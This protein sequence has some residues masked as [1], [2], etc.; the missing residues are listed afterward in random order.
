MAKD[1][2]STGAD[3]QANKVNISTPIPIRGTQL[4]QID[5]AASAAINSASNPHASFEDS[6][7]SFTPN[8]QKRVPRASARRASYSTI[9]TSRE[10]HYNLDYVADRDELDRLQLDPNSRFYARSRPRTLNLPRLLPYEVENPQNQAKFLSHIVS[11][12]YIAI[13]TL[14]I[15]GSLSVSARDLA[16]LRDVSGFSDIDIAL[17]T[18]LFESGGPEKGTEADHEEDNTYFQDDIDSASESPDEEDEDDEYDN[19]NDDAKDHENTVQ[20]KKSPKS[21]AVVGVRIWTQELLVWLKMKYEMPVS[22]RMNLARVY[23]AVCLSRGQHISLK[24]YVR[25]FELLTKDIQFLRSQQFSLPWEDMYNELAHH[26]PSVDSSQ[27]RF[28]KKDHKQLLRLAERASNFFDPSSLPIIFQKLGSHFSMPN[29]SL[30]LSATALLPLNF[31]DNVDDDRDI[32]HYLSL[33]FYIWIKMNKSPGVDTHMTTRL[34]AIAM[35]HYIVIAN[36]KNVL[37]PGKVFSD[38]QI[39][40]IFNILLN[41][42]SIRKEKYSSAKT[43]FFHGFASAIIFSINGDAALERGGIFEQLESLGNAIESYVHPSNSGE[44]SRSISKTILALVYQFQKRVNLE[45]EKDALLYNLPQHM[46]LTQKMKDTMIDIFLPKIRI[47]LQSK[48]PNVTDDYLAALCLIAQLNPPKVLEF[49]LLDIYESLEGTLSTHR[50]V[51]ALRSLEELARYFAS[52]PIFRVHVAR[53]LLLALP[54]IDSN[55]LEK[56]LLT[57]NVFASFANYVPFYDLSNGEGD[58]TMAFEF[59]QQHL[60]TLQQRIYQ[61]TEFENFQVD[62]DLERNALVS[63]SS[64]FKLLLKSLNQRIFILLENVPDPSKS[65]GLEQALESSLPKFMYVLLEAISDDIL[66]S[67]RDDFFTF[68]LENTIEGIG[69]IVAEICGGIIK[70]DPTAFEHFCIELIEKIRNEVDDNGA[71]STR[72]G[73]DV[74]PRD[75]VLFWNLLILNECIG[76]AGSQVLKCQTELNDLSFYLME[77]IKGPTV[78]ASSYLLNQ[79]LQTTTKIRLNEQRL[80]SPKYQQEHGMSERCWGGF[81]TENSRFLKENLT[82]DWFIPGEKEITF[83]IDTFSSHVSHILEK[84]LELMKENTTSSLVHNLLLQ[85]SDKLTTCF[86]YLSY[87]LSG[88]SFLLDPSFD[89]DIPQLGQLLYQSVQ[90]RLYLL[91]QIRGVGLG[92]NKEGELRIDNLHENLEQIVQ[93]LD[94]DDSINYLMDVDK[95]SDFL[96][97]DAEEPKE[98]ESEDTPESKT[99]ILLFDERSGVKSHSTSP[100]PPDESARATP[101]IEGMN[102]SSMN[103]SLTF[104]ERKL[105]TSKY[106]F[107]DDIETRRANPSYLKLHKSRILIGRALHVIG[108][109]LNL[110]FT[111]STQLFKHYLF[112]VNMWFSDLGRERKLDSSEACVSYGYFKTL[113]NV[114][115]V[116]KPFTRMAFG[117]RI[118]SYHHLRVALH[119]TSRTQ[120]DLDKV[121]LEDVIKLAVSTYSSIAKPAQATLVDAMGRLNGS[122]NVLVRSIFKH[123]ENALHKKDYK[124]VESALRVFAIKRIKTRIQNDYYN[125]QKF[126]SVLLALLEVGNLE[127][128]SI[129][130]KLYQGIHEGISLPSSVCL[131][132]LEQIDTIRPPDQFIDLEIKAVCLAKERKRKSYFERLKSLENFVIASEKTTTHWKVSSLNLHLLVDLQSDLEME[133]NKDALQILWERSASDHPITSRLSLRGITKIVTKL[134]V[135]ALLDHKLINGYDFDYLP[136]DFKVIPTTSPVGQSYSSIWH[137]EMKEREHPSYF[138]DHKA[139]TGWLFWGD[140]MVAVSNKASYSM[141][142]SKSEDEALRELGSRM[143]RDWFLNIVN[144]WISDNEANFAFQG[145]DVFVTTT[146]THLISC[147]YTKNFTFDELLSLV[148]QIYVGDEKSTHIVTCELIAGILVC[149]KTL[150]PALCEKRDKHISELLTNILDNDLSPDTRGIWNIFSWWIPAHIDCRRFPL[151]NDV[152]VNFRVQPDSASALKE[153]TRLSYIRSHIAAV[154]WGFGMSEEIFSASLDNLRNKYRAIRDQTGSILAVLSFGFFADS[155]GSSTEFIELCNKE[156]PKYLLERLKN[157]VMFERI[158]KLFREVGEMKQEVRD[159]GTQVILKSPYIAA[160]T[161]LL[162]WLGQVLNTSVAVLYQEYIDTYIIP[163][164]LDLINLKEV[165]QLGDIDPISVFKHASQIQYLPHMLERIVKAIELYA[166]E[167]LNAVQCFIMGEFTETFFFKNLFELS[168]SQ[169]YR[170]IAV[171]SELLYHKNVEVREAE[172]STFAGLIH[173][174]P[175]KEV[176]EI[177]TTS[178]AKYEK[179]LDDVRKKHRKSGYKQMTTEE[180]VAIHGACLGLGALVHAFLFQSPPPPW[181]PKVL[182]ILANKASGIPGV[183]GKTS[184][185]TLGRF[186]K[187]RQDTWHVD[188]KVF[189]EDQIQDLEGVLWRSYYI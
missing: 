112:A 51:V 146:I 125:L 9:E 103:P 176:D 56:T 163:F 134:N 3:N 114:N 91:K 61:E 170:I 18:N 88:I 181:V 79:L 59:T 43:K 188:S 41:S 165:C 184:R 120:T 67:F 75:Q 50:V 42:L 28:E 145:S 109:F 99:A 130:Q 137:N 186:K 12:L 127:V 76:N 82:F 185:D 69:D 95:M 26:F 178:C 159:Q 70:R 115:R 140:S 4:N 93:D 31:T 6:Y 68:A 123:L 45:N 121:L 53:L 7:R 15:Q 135:M 167:D 174:S 48:K 101:T 173:L 25:T 187:T 33:L 92:K 72:T 83:A 154:T 39:R 87:S 97:I 122:Y 81:L 116:R 169:R 183:V 94:S 106:Y 175:P 179:E 152:I 133:I 5:R 139:N 131:I 62:D 14:D 19:D 148:E 153:A 44:W 58:P 172:A 29:I 55:D 86:L 161:T 149:S 35:E 96:M 136:P 124:K 23:Y 132:D 13:K 10:S 20:H 71:G 182:S 102:M 104:R 89:E 126:V 98:K 65:T 119:A 110:N 34:G 129:A 117:S 47:G 150:H 38:A 74:L 40:T 171:T 17:E 27:E 142:L 180:T 138:I 8:S 111:D 162:T 37:N 84:V 100:A 46:K 85:M 143:T 1:T 107:G 141:N 64:S 90:Q 36:G 144:L 177:V 128:N 164:L 113:Q 166:K 118:E 22:L 54:G 32:R 66:K 63:S 57:L 60:E 157:N 73:F 30:V 16:L 52:T 11:H 108:K 78:F 80:I 156:G 160:A 155:I 49:V 24:I 2:R 189:N 147:G 158:P 77:R 21:A 105:Y 151:I 168:P